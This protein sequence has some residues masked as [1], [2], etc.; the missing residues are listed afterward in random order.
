M[1]PEQIKLKIKEIQLTY[2][3]AVTVAAEE[4]DS[5]IEKV[6]S[7]CKHDFIDVADLDG[8]IGYS[9]CKIC[10]IDKDETQV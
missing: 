10:G 8:Y 7:L 2:K 3:K 9:Y 6:Q 4:Y 1:T 5:A